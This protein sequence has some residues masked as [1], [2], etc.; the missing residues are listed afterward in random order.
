MSKYIY[1]RYVIKT[2]LQHKQT[3]QGNCHTEL[4]PQ[5]EVNKK[6]VVGQELPIQPT[7]T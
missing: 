3:Q 4:W 1:I 5:Y 2:T 7:N 6:Q